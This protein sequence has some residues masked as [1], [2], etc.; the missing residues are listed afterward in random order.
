MQ[1]TMV[2]AL[3]ITAENG[4]AYVPDCA[5]FYNP[6]PP[7]DAVVKI[8]L[9]AAGFRTIELVRSLTDRV[10]TSYVTEPPLVPTDRVCDALAVSYDN[11]VVQSLAP[12]WSVDIGSLNRLA[13]STRWRVDGGA[14]VIAVS[15]IDDLGWSQ[16]AP[17]R[18]SRTFWSIA[19]PPRPIALTVAEV[20]HAYTPQGGITR[21]SDR[22]HAVDGV[23]LANGD[24]VTDAR[25]TEWY[26]DGRLLADRVRLNVDE[27]AIKVVDATL[28]VPRER[29]APPPPGYRPSRL[30]ELVVRWWD[31]GTTAFD[32]RSLDAGAAEGWGWRISLPVATV[33]DDRSICLGRHATRIDA[34]TA[35]LCLDKKGTWDRPC[36]NDAEC[37]FYDSRQGRGGCDAGFCE[38]PLGVDRLSFRKAAN[39]GNAMFVGCGERDPTFPRCSNGGD[40]VLFGSGV[41]PS[42]YAP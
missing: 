16:P 2:R 11:D 37:P 9:T 31:D 24:V 5:V 40:A 6:A 30:Y 32:A 29:G 35:A 19:G 17:V 4:V 34:A 28:V 41:E 26:Y 12:G 33:E 15:G 27:S 42:A 3:V 14:Q 10:T 13:P 8:A 18:G 36:T 22:L 39:P 20:P 38:M 23:A 21:V 7:A 1:T 25:G